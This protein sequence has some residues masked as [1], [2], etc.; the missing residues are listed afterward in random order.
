MKPNYEHHFDIR[1]NRRFPFKYA[2][3]TEMRIGVHNWHENLEIL[4]ITGGEGAVRYGA[5]DLSAR[6]GDMFVINT[7]VFHQVHSTRGIDFG[8]LIIDESFCTENGLSADD[9]FFER[10]FRDAN[11]EA[12]FRAVAEASRDTAHSTFIPRLRC[13]VLALLIHLCEHHTL[14]ENLHLSAHSPGEDYVKRTVAYLAEHFPEPQSLTKLAAL[15]GISEYHLARVFKQYTGETVFA[16]L[17]T[18]RCRHAEAAISA[19]ATVTEAA[20]S[21]GFDALPYFSRTYK[22]IIGRSPSKTKKA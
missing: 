3:E 19:G 8:Y 18:I 1:K 17:N 11:A 13:A 7:D 12:L 21:V 20:L 14:A 16:H 5:E 22:K 4:L 10:H 2:E 6:P 15:S 9:L